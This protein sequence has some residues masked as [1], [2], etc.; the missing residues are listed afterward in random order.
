MLSNWEDCGKED[1]QQEMNQHYGIGKC[2]ERRD[3]P[4]K[5]LSTDKL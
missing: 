3:R 5:H 1:N 4:E 2:L